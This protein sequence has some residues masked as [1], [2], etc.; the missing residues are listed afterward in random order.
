[1]PI[2]SPSLVFWSSSALIAA[3]TSLFG[4]VVPALPEFADKLSLSDAEAA[5]IFALFPVGALLSSVAGA[6]LVEA[7]GRRPVMLLSVLVMAI[8]TVGFAFSE[9][10]ILFASSRAIQGVATGLAWTAALAAISD[11]FPASELG[12]RMSLAEAVGGAGG[13]LAGPAV[14]GLAIDLIGVRPTFLVAAVV[15]LLVA[16]PVLLSGET[17]RIAERPTISRRAALRLI[18]HQ[19]RARVAAA[20]L[21]GFAMVLGLIE[22]LLPLDL[23]RRLELSAAAIG[24]V[25]GTLILSDLITAPIAGRWSDRRGR[26]APV[27]AGGVLIAAALPLTAVGPAATVVV[28]V[29]LLGVGLG[30]FGAGIGALMTEAVDAAGLAGQYGLSAGIMSAIF[31]I[32]ALAGP[33]LGGIARTV[34]P[35]LATVGLLALFIA[36]ATLWMV[37]T[38]VR[39]IDSEAANPLA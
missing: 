26:V 32:G 4:L 14:G 11:V 1:M 6:A 2:R 25:F 21:V 18:M 27:A 35:Y 22:P 30:S 23:D 15:P 24:L 8:A 33:L 5:L 28:A 29:V 13:G 39:A 7:V 20:A 38:L 12:Y 17:R 9:E 3:E 16:I 37:R 19:P 31:S 10:V 36:G 34:L